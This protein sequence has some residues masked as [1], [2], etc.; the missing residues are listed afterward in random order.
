VVEVLESAFRPFACSVSISPY[1]QRI[2]FV[3]LDSSGAPILRPAARPGLE[4]R[5]PD[6]LRLRIDQARS[7]LRA[8]G[9]KI[10]RWRSSL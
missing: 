3:I 4:M 5:D 7:R 8:E 10:D 1:K 9:F 2:R 6:S